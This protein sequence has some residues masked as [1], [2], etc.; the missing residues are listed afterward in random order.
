LE[1]SK[2]KLTRT[3]IYPS[4]SI[5]QIDACYLRRNISRQMFKEC[6]RNVA[7]F[8]CSIFINMSRLFAFI[9][10]SIAIVFAALYSVYE[11]LKGVYNGCKSKN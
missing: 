11:L 4:R 3:R 9:Q 1:S 8:L 2:R 6:S 7:L 10:G 5:S